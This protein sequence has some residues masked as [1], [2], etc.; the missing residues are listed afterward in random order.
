MIGIVYLFLLLPA[1]AVM[2]YVIAALIRWA[3]GA[4]ERIGYSLVIF[5]FSMMAGMLGGAS[6]YFYRPDLSSLELAAVLNFILM[7]VGIMGV[8]YAFITKGKGKVAHPGSPGRGETHDRTHYAAFISVVILLALLNE[9]LMGLSFSL[10]SGMTPVSVYTPAGLISTALNS[11]WFTLT[12]G[13]EMLLTTYYFRN[14]VPADLRRVLLMQGV[15]MLLSPPA[16]EPLGLSEFSIYAGS[17]WMI[18]LFI[19]LFDYFYRNRSMNK[20]LSTYILLLVALYSVMMPSLFYWEAGGSDLLFGL[21]LAF[22]MVLFFDAVLEYRRFD[23]SSRLNWLE[24]PW[25]TVSLLFLVFVSEYF[26]GATL[27]VQYYGVAFLLSSDAV[28]L[29]GPAI[30]IMSKAAYDFIM[31]VSLVTNSAWFYIMMGSEMGFLVFMQ[32][33]RVKQLETKVRLSLVIVAYALY[34]VFFPYFFFPRAYLPRVPFLGWNMGL[35]TTGPAAPLFLVAIIATYLISGLLAFLFGGRQVCSL[36]CSAAL[37]Y[38]GTFYDAAKG[39]NRK[40]SLSK[41]LARNGLSRTYVIVSSLVWLSMISTAAISYL[42]YT[43]VTNISVFGEDPLVFAYSFYL[44]FLWY[45]IFI[46]IPFV[47]TYGC[48]TTGMCSWGMFNQFVG[49]LGFWRLKAKDP[50]ECVRCKTKDCVAACPVGL[51]AI[52]GSFIRTGEFRS[53]KCIGVG[54]CASACPVDNILFYDVRHFIR[55]HISRRK[56]IEEPSVLGTARTPTLEHMDDGESIH[57]SARRLR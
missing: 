34:T 55:D 19:Y 50:Y 8:L 49:R 37:M 35:G 6:I 36:F 13:A 43:G 38:Q 45:I 53:Y 30:S 7:P 11:Y 16:L 24:K 48:V 5:I 51:T 33:R 26:M 17:L 10:I 20:P 3:S 39:F 14:R 4:R 52:P 23:T 15:I 32:I 25:W 47:G 12:M 42:D 2:V 31:Y 21:T 56:G 1:A 41:M 46:T 57:A 29:T 54:E 18:I 44:N 40:T 28:S 22:E 9:V 27:D